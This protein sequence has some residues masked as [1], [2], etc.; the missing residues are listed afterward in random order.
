[1]IRKTK[2][3]KHRQT[4]TAETKAKA[5]AMYLRGLY[6]TEISILLQ[7]PIRTLENW[8]T[9]EKW[10]AYKETFECKQR[11]FELYKTGKKQQAIAELMQVSK[12]T[13]SRWIKTAKDSAKK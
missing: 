4:Y 1:M 3:T 7:T 8:Q 2:T 12:A 10:T 11:A 5:K 9:A 6:L 13:I